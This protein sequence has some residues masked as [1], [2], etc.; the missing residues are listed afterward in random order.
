MAGTG[1]GLKD[2]IGGRIAVVEEE[3]RQELRAG[4]ASWRQGRRK[5]GSGRT[6]KRTQ[7]S[8]RSDHIRAPTTTR[9]RRGDQGLEELSSKHGVRKQ[10]IRYPVGNFVLF[11]RWR[12]G[13]CTE[14]RRG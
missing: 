11:A 5:S 4:G 9:K 8:I 14:Y 10:R 7:Q 3:S 12:N 13:V 6:R 1:K 2:L